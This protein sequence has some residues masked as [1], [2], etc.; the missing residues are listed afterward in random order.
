MFRIRKVLDDVQP[1]NREAL[2]QVK[3]LLRG[4]FKSLDRH[5]LE[6]IREC[7]TNPFK[8][9]YRSILYVAENDKNTVLG[10]ALFYHEPVLRYC[11]L[12]Y[13]ASLKQLTGRGIGGALYQRVTDECRQLG[14][15]GIF[16][17]ALPD[18]PLLCRDP[19][20]LKQNQSRLRFYE[21][22]GAR[23][24][25]G[26]A[27]ETPVEEGGDNPPYLLFDDLGLETSLRNSWFRKVV[28]S[29]LMRVHKGVCSSRYLKMVL[30]SISDDPV[31][32]RKIRY[33]RE[34]P[35][36]LSGLTL[37]RQKKILLVVNSR[38]DILH[39][40]ER[41]YVEAPVRVE[42]ILKGLNALPFFRTVEVRTYPDRYLLAVHSERYVSYLKKACEKSA[43]FGA[44]YPNIYP[45]RVK[46]RPDGESPAHAGFYIYDSYT[47]IHENSFKAPRAAVNCCLTAAELILEG[48]NLVYALVRPPG[49]HAERELVGGFCYFNNAAVAAQ[50]L[51]RYGRVAVV[52]VDYHHGNGQQEIFYSRR[53]VLT[54]SLHRHPREAYP[55]FSGFREER[56]DGEGKGYNLNSPLAGNVTGRQYLEELKLAM[57]KVG[58]F[59][60]SYLVVCLGFD[61]ARGDPTGDWLLGSTDFRGMGAVFGRLS[62]PT[63]VVQEGGYLNRSLGRNA[64]AF[65]NGLYRTHCLS[66]KR[67]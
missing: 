30:D 48:N 18:D 3:E 2:L 5:Y 61:T 45:D 38:H 67:C 4:S 24:V 33:S 46:T 36:D 49:H 16:F 47:P 27:Y 66:G 26:T 64:A 43:G 9:R 58:R 21:N 23:P 60:P 50:F 13:L 19:S 52:D 39:V 1:V 62:L 17:E 65:F 51:S 14:V 63:L 42:A 31:Q 37:D 54:V 6:S 15:E 56:G 29:I 32:V 35:V 40:R 25:I 7:L 57:Q 34:T 41:G 8:Y 11:Y 44:I 22:F 59:S 20:M 55:Y 53:D 28:S 10:M 12:D